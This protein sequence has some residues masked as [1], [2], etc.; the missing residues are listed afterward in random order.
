MQLLRFGSDMEKDFKKVRHIIDEAL[1]DGVF[2]G[3][4]LKV[5]KGDETLFEDCFGVTDFDTND[6]VTLKTFFDLAS[7]TKVLSTT[8]IIIKLVEEKKIDVNDKASSY[9]SELKGDKKEILISQLLN[10]SSG[11]PAHK[12][13]FKSLNEIGF[14]ERKE[15]LRNFLINEELEAD[16]GEKHIYSDLGFMLLEWIIEVVTGK[17]LDIN[18]NEMCRGL[19]IE[20]LFYT[21]MDPDQSID[22][23]S[24][25]KCIYRGV[26]KGVVHDDNCYSVGGVCGHA[27]LFGT[28]DGVSKLLCEVLR[29][30]KDTNGF[31]NRE[32][33]RRFIQRGG[34]VK[35]PLGFDSP[36]KTDSSCGKFFSYNS[37][38]HLGFTGTSFWI[39]FDNEIIVILL[40]NRVHPSREN[41][42]IRKFRPLLHNEVIRAIL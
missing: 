10:H 32:V 23:A 41:I 24:T 8:L 16:P 36:S 39:D 7:L 14:P 4:V 21:G 25:E 19:N 17:N 20:E 35:K 26:L 12:E 28:I 31:F 38:G 30:V 9:I 1:E 13:Y 15:S 29:S 11:Y 27:G 22:F 37:A 42:K 34:A 6:A 18:F 3:G 33:L 2:P 40:T 5:I